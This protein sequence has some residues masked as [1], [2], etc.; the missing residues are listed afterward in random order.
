MRLGI[1]KKNPLPLI[2]KSGVSCP[3]GRFSPSFIHQVINL[4][5]LNKLYDC[6]S[7][8]LPVNTNHIYTKPNVQDYI[9][10][11]IGWL[12]S[13]PSDNSVNWPKQQR[14]SFA[15][16]F[17]FSVETEF[18]TDTNCDCNPFEPGLILFAWVICT[19][20]VFGRI[21]SF[22]GLEYGYHFF[23]SNT[24]ALLRHWGSKRHFLQREECSWH[25]C[26]V[27]LIDIE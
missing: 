2:E 8:Y 11:M 24:W 3:G 16:G 21:D 5:G 22:G 18:W 27:H 14:P 13:K 17:K 1:Y 15:I 19:D 6:T 26:S 9:N 20:N 23:T 25:T 4:T 7:T 12:G 10:E